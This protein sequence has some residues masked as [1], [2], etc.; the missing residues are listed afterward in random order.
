MWWWFRY[1][2][3]M[4]PHLHRL[5]AKGNQPTPVQAYYNAPTYR[6]RMVQIHCSSPEE[7]DSLWRLLWQV[8][9]HAF[10]P[11]DVFLDGTFRYRV[12]RDDGVQTT[13]RPA[14]PPA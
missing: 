13:A 3:S 4:V 14:D 10:V 11:C 6:F 7:I 5:G 2:S 1:C 12:V 8:P 9:D